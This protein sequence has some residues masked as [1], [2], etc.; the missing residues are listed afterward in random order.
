MIDGGRATVRDLEVWIGDQKDCIW[1]EVEV[2]DF[3]WVVEKPRSLAGKQNPAV[4]ETE[5]QQDFD[6]FGGG[7]S[8]PDQGLEAVEDKACLP[9]PT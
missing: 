9:N 2:P 4:Q 7:N 6:F 3:G 8:F 5:A 1:A